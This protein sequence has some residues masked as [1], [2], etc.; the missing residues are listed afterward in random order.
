MLGIADKREISL[1]R[2]E[3]LTEFLRDIDGIQAIMGFGSLAEIERFDQYSD[4]DFLI[5][6]EQDTRNRLLITLEVFNEVAPITYVGIEGEDTVRLLFSD[7]VLCDF[8]VVTEKQLTSIP[9]GQGRYIWKTKEF[10]SEYIQS[11][12]KL[13]NKVDKNQWCGNVLIELYVGLLRELRGEK[14]AA[15]EK[16]QYEA[17]QKML[18]GLYGDNNLTRMDYFSALRRIEKIGVNVNILRKVMPGYKENTK[19]AR[20]II[21]CLPITEELKGLLNEIEKLIFLCEKKYICTE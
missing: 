18:R 8:G 21:S 17:V 7:G 13:K 3:K 5:V 16:I 12:I 4:L 11:T 19:A 2:M 6:C 1:V 20:E 10:S 9:H 14:A 15:F